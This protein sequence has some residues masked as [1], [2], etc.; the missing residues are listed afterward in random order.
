MTETRTAAGVSGSTPH[1]YTPN[2]IRSYRFGPS[3][4]ER[5]TNPTD[6]ASA[7]TRRTRTAKYGFEKSTVARKPAMGTPSRHSVHQNASIRTESVA[8]RATGSQYTPRI[9]VGAASRTI[10]A[11]ETAGTGIADASFGSWRNIARTIR[12]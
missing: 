5:K 4:W 11:P 6:I 1:S 9:S 10:I 7:M 3:A 8:I 12:A 2:L